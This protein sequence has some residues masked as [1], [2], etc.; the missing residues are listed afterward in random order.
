MRTLDCEEQVIVAG[1]F[2]S[3]SC[4]PC[5]ED[6]PITDEVTIPGKRNPSNSDPRFGATNLTIIS[7]SINIMMF[8]DA[9]DAAVNAEELLRTESGRPAAID[10]YSS[11]VIGYSVDLDPHSVKDSVDYEKA[12][13]AVFDKMSPA[14]LKA[15]DAQLERDYKNAMD[16]YNFKLAEFLFGFKDANGNPSK[17]GMASSYAAQNAS[18]FTLGLIEAALARAYAVAAA[19]PGGI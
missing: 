19:L 11:G 2:G 4:P 14:E 8:R 1:G 7:G 13:K 9:W 10:E 17:M 16:K 18:P 12:W 5:P 6:C 15:F 3:F